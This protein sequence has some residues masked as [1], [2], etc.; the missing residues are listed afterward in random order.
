MTV[1]DLILLLQTQ[2][3]AALVVTRNMDGGLWY[4]NHVG[5]VKDMPVWLDNTRPIVEIAS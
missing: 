2:D 4:T 5:P 1:F 3:P